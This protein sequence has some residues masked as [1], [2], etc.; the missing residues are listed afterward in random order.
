MAHIPVLL[1][2]VCEQLQLKNGDVAIDGTAGAGG[3][4]IELAKQVSPKG[5]VIAIDKDTAALELAK[6]KLKDFSKN[7]SLFHG[8]YDNLKQIT[9]D[10]DVSQVQGIL[11][12]LGLSSMQLDE[13]NRGF[14]FNKSAELDMRFDLSAELTAKEVVN[15][16]TEKE[17]IEIF[18]QYGEEKLASPI[19]KKIVE[20][21]KEKPISTT[22]ELAE[23]ISKVYRRFYKRDSRTHPAT[24]IFQALRIEVNQEL[25][26]VKKVLPDAIEMLSPG[27]RLAVIS[28]HSLE[29]KIIKDFF[30]KETIDCIC[31]PSFPV[32]QCG[33]QK[34]IKLVNKKPIIPSDKEIRENPRSRSAKL[35]VVEKINNQNKK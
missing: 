31:P 9:L 3:H 34:S 4:T 27:G 1:N 35:R 20:L 32:C 6:K 10:N 7:V 2:E 21:R 12:D 25:E 26:S 33:H 23:I 22:E 17:L 14:S 29:D 18:R 15:H 8:N 13:G 19:A 11:L 30:K 16:Y 24:K 5:K 28:Y